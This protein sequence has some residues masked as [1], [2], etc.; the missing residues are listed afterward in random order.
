VTKI[1]KILNKIESAKGKEKLEILMSQ[2]SNDALKEV[3]RLAYSPT[4]QFYIK[5]VP[6]GWQHS[7]S[8]VPD[9]EDV[10]TKLGEL[11]SREITGDA[12]KDFLMKDIL[13]Y[14][15]CEMAE[16]VYR[17]IQ[18]D[19]KCGIGAS[20]INKVWKNLIVKPPR[21]GASSMNEKSLA[22]MNT[23]KNL[24]IELKSDGSYASSVCGEN[25]TMMS[26]NGNPLEV[27]CLQ[28]HLECGAFD[29]FALEGELVYSLDKATREEGNGIITKIVKG[30]ASE[31]E[32]ENA[33]YQV[34]DCI[35]ISYYEPKG[36]YPFSNECRRDLLVC[37][38]E[39]YYEWCA[40]NDVEEKI[41]LIPRRENVS[42][43]EAFEIF[44]GY[45]REGYE[46]AIVKDMDATW[47]DSGKPTYCV[48]LKRKEPCDLKVVGW[49]EAEKGSKY[50]GLLG[51][52]HCESSCGKIKVNVGS[53]FSDEERKTL[54]KDLPPIIE[55]EYDSITKDKKTQ[56]ESLFLPIYKRPRYDKLEADSYNDILDKQ[57]IKVEV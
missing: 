49:Y 42:V 30:T 40:D 44:E 5:K 37:M 1:L 47:K 35:D 8:R 54:M 7:N 18:K 57:K 43:D 21:Q 3:C 46:G 20:T 29:G 4:T 10:F 25:S 22:K 45:V 39:D 13:T 12:A 9:W 53:G 41:I 31:E 33:L 56:Q 19:L 32:K 38:M 17:I 50:E 16:V 2:K 26:R 11:S 36:E 28:K 14:I 52:L 23:I 55:V 51:G 15:D 27:E 6:D 24:A 34:W 48:K